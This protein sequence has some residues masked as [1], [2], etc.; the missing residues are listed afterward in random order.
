MIE[1]LRLEF[2]LDKK[3]AEIAL[4]QKDTELQNAEVFNQRIIHIGVFS[5]VVHVCYNKHFSIP[6]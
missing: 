1:R 5:G 2:D 4:L 6:K 3:E